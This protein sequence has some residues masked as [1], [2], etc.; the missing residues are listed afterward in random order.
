MYDSEVSHKIDAL[1]KAFDEIL[2]VI[3]DVVQGTVLI[4]S[5]GDIDKRLKEDWKFAE[6]A[7]HDEY[8]G[9]DQ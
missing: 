7:G 6:M 4:K 5:L 2:W 9:E 8:M 1:R 3:S